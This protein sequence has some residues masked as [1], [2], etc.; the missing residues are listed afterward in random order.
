MFVLC[1]I[2]G[3]MRVSVREYARF[4]MLAPRYANIKEEVLC[5]LDKYFFTYSKE[6]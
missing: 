2:G 5:R 3:N 4:F 1:S 6:G